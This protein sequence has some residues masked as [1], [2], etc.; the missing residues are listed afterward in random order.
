M[1][2]SLTT[3]L[4]FSQGQVSRD[5]ASCEHLATSIPSSWQVSAQP[6]KWGW[7]GPRQ[8]PLHQGFSTFSALQRHMES[9][10]S[11]ISGPQPQNFWVSLWGN[12]R[13]KT[14]ALR[15]VFLSAI[16]AAPIISQSHQQRTSS[17]FSLH[18]HQHLL[19]LAFFFFY[20][21]HLDRCEMISHCG[22][23]LPFSDD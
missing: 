4:L 17:P 20:D 12:E 14:G 16:V 19:F 5:G 23:D 21:S 9:F 3:W 18:L 13:Q 2:T 1:I 11:Q 15:F 7:V 22:F 8:H 10:F 6:G